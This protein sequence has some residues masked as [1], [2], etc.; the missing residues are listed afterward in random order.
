MISFMNCDVNSNK[1]TD[2]PVVA[3]RPLG[4]SAEALSLS[5]QGT[6][7]FRTG[8]VLINERP[9]KASAVRA[10]AAAQGQ[11]YAGEATTNGAGSTQHQQHHTMWAF[12]G[13]E[14][15]RDPA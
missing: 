9:T 15:W 5:F 13:L 6:G 7:L 12:R 14:P 2:R 8:S 4:L 3:I 1:M 11:T 10:A